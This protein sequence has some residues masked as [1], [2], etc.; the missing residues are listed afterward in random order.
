MAIRFKLY[1][2]HRVCHDI[3]NIG[4][5]ALGLT[6]F[7]KTPDPLNNRARTMRLITGFLK[8]G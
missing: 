7:Y 2:T 4:G 1:Q 3:G 6:T 8:G 5:L